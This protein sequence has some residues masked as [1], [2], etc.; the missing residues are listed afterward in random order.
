MS[1]TNEHQTCL[2][3]PLNFE[4]V[5]NCEANVG[6]VLHFKILL[7]FLQVC[8]DEVKNLVLRFTGLPNFKFARTF[9]FFAKTVKIARISRLLLGTSVPCFSVFYDYDNFHKNR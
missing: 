4:S 1:T 8:V 2:S 7:L 5:V 6:D 3:K 9:K